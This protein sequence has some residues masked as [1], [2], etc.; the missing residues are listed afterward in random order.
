M[1]QGGEGMF[2]IYVT[3]VKGEYMQSGTYFLQKVAASLISV[4]AS[5]KEQTSP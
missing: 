1:G 5:H 2:S 3:L 4:T